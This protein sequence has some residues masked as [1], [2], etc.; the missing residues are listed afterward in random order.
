M[1]FQTL[2]QR[3][4]DFKSLDPNFCVYKGIEKNLGGL[5]ELSVN[6]NMAQLGKYKMFLKDLKRVNREELN[7]SEKIDLQLYELYLEQSCLE[8]ELE[9][10]GAA[11]M[12]RMP[13]GSSHISGPIFMLFIND[14]REDRFRLANIISRLEKTPS[15]L[16]SYQKTLY[17]PVERWTD[18]EIAKIESL[19]SLFDSIITWAQKIEFKQI[20][21]LKKSIET[22]QMA[23]SQ[24]KEH[25]KRQVKTKNIFLG[26]EQMNR[27]IKSKGIELSAFELKKIAENFLFENQKQVEELKE[28]LILKYNLDPNLSSY[29]VQTFLNQKYS[30]KKSG[31]G[32]GFVLERYQQE[33]EKVLSYIK[34]KNLFP[35]MDD[36][37]MNIMQTPSFMKPTI[38]AG[39]MMEPPPFREGIKTSLV[40][41][42]LSEELL[43]EHTEISI[44]CMMIHEGI[45]GHHLQFAHAANNPSH[46]RKIFS[47]M[48]LSE[49]WTTMLEDYML[50][51]GYAGE[52]ELEM[53]FS[54]KRDIARIG[55]RV[56]IDLYFMS[57]DISYLDIGLVKNFESDDPFV[58]AGQ[59]LKEVTG[60]TDD[61]VQGE[62]NWYSQERGYPLCYLT[63][64]HLVWKLKEDFKNKFSDQY[65]TEQE[66]DLDF[67]TKFLSAGN[68]P[69]S[70]L[71][72][73]LFNS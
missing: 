71:R 60:F 26:P 32:F 67:H 62:L 29:G 56:L 51:Q 70:L 5:P 73:F 2:T 34:E 17:Q 4:T 24:Y 52:L 53:R 21:R 35:V 38:P 41:L 31:E 6:K 65:K 10:D 12:A 48:D 23:L 59:L 69:V 66:L 64:N 1:N 55:A 11:Q 16:N 54:G 45:P 37:D 58:N 28:K 8:F 33:R 72:D 47:A 40:Y 30:V 43:D 9:I 13:M 42:T 44:P 36:Q 61:R 15:F 63:G 27:V 3:F 7:L 20:D 25:L 22:A 49:G 57:G 50:D 46:I 18:M 19:P 68:M 14:K 39:A